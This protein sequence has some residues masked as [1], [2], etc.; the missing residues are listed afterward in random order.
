MKPGSMRDPSAPVFTPRQAKVWWFLVG[1]GCAA[2]VSIA[3][4]LCSLSSV[5]R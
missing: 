5:I 4:G 1:V 2:L 3:Y